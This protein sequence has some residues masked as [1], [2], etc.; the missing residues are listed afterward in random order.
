MGCEKNKTVLITGGAGYIGGITVRDLLCAG[1]DIVVLDNFVK[2]RHFAVERNRVFAERSGRKFSLKEGDL[3]DTNFLRDVFSEKDIAAVIHFAAFIEVAESV[4]RPAL[5]FYNNIISTVH[6]LDAMA[7]AGIKRIVFSSSAAVYGVPDAVPIQENS[8]TLPINPY[9]YTKLSMEKIIGAYR[10]AFGIE[11]IAL[12]YFNAA[13]A[14][15][16]AELGEAHFPESHLL[17]N[18]IDMLTRGMPVR[19]FGDDYETDD[20]TCLRDYIS[21]ADLARAHRSALELEEE[22]HLNRPYNLGS[23]KG[24]TVGN[25][26]KEVAA[27]LGVEAK[28]QHLPRRPGDPDKLVASS[29]AF[30]KA[31]RWSPE[32][33]H[34]TD[35]IKTAVEW[36]A[37]RPAESFEPK[38]APSSSEHELSKK[39][40]AEL[41]ANKIIPRATKDDILTMLE[42]YSKGALPDAVMDTGDKKEDK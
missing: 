36:R 2:G 28:T 3:S 22:K 40:T 12:R 14:V 23:E 16:G 39:I 24:F 31:T 41:R 18:A 33:S 38:F 37:K 9:G 21:V 6:L 32:N 13:G 4:D 27:V 20:G 19:I 5:Y 1:Y 10:E 35:I 26:A 7:E 29:Q 17:P 15:P 42:K 8:P 30:R 34:I 11:W 25:I